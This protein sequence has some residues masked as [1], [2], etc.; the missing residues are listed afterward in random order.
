MVP[1]GISRVN[2][3]FFYV[4]NLVGLIFTPMGLAQAYYFLPKLANTPIYSHRLSM[5]GFW[6]IA[7]LYAWIG[8]HHIIHG[9]V[10]Q[11]LQTT[12]IVFSIWLF[13]PVWTVVDKPFC[14]AQTP[15][16]R[17]YTKRSHQIFDDGEHLLPA[18]LHSGATDGAAQ[19]QRNHIKNRLGHRPFPYLSLCDIYLLRHRRDLSG[20]SCHYRKSRS[21]RRLWLIGTFRSIS[22]AASPFSLRYGWAA[23]FREWSGRHGQTALP[24]SSITTI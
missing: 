13:I 3:S 6:S 18:D 12:S 16:V 1:G 2:V 11:W 9:P 22:L 24:I 14:D 7:F 10:S 5:V 4:H 17:L 20:H 19:Y 21:G 23:F 15:M 8:A